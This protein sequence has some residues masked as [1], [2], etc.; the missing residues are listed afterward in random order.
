MLL[1]VTINA[2]SI[3]FKSSANNFIWEK[4]SLT[5]SGTANITVAGFDNSNHYL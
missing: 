2:S 4:S 1:G 3:F 5:V